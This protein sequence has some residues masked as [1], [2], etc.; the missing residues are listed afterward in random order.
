MPDP[1]CAK[2]VLAPEPNYRLRARG[3]EARA[4]VARF[5]Y[6]SLSRGKRAG[7]RRA[8][9]RGAPEKEVAGRPPG[10]QLP[11]P[12][13]E[14][15]ARTSEKAKCF[16]IPAKLSVFASLLS[17]YCRIFPRGGKVFPLCRWSVERA[18]E[19][20]VF[21]VAARARPGKLALGTNFPRVKLLVYIDGNPPRRRALRTRS[22]AA[23]HGAGACVTSAREHKVIKTQGKERSAPEQGKSGKNNNQL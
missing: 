11:R 3:D 1:F 16:R 21:P 22:S 13:R 17:P 18:P 5:L 4:R 2:P 23:R 20:S 8:P 19:G 12:A 6:F 15:V 7:G 14:P 10:N 9:A